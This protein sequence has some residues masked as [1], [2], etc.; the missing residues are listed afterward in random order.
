MGERYELIVLGAGPGGYVAAIKAAQ[1]GHRVAVVESRDVGG[2]C[3][4][5]GCI[6]TKPL[7]HAAE[8]LEEIRSCEKL[9]IHVGQVSY[10]FAGMHERKAEVVEQLRGGIEGLFK[11]YKIDLIR[12]CGI[13]L[14]SN[15]IQV[16]DQAYETD[17]ILIATGS[18]PA[19]P[20]IPGLT[21]PGVVTSDEMLEGKGVYCK[22][23]VIIG[24]GVI[25][26]EFAT[27]YHALGCEVTIIEALD[28]I[29]PTLDREVSQNLT[30]ILK[31]RGI[32]VYTGA[33]VDRVE[34][35][36]QSVQTAQEKGLAVYFMSKEKEQCVETERVLVSIGRRANTEGICPPSLNLQMQRGMIPV[37]DSFETCIKGIYAIGDIVLGGIQ[38]AHVASAQAVN[39]VCSMFGERAPMNLS[40]IPSCIYTNPEIAAVG[41]TA[42]EAKMR[43]IRTITGK[44]IMSSNG[45]TVI[46]MADR[47]FVKLVFEEESKVLLGA[48]LMCSRATDMITGL[49]DGVAGKLTMS[50]LAATVR[51]HPTFSE[52]I[53]EAIE[54][55]DGGAIHAAPRRK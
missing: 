4:N 39:A 2:T 17:R 9:G 36:D 54:D 37:D 7:V 16:G 6:P 52:A 48:V 22:K 45:K 51:P 33:R 15:R 30:M 47:G 34:H 24:G 41:M 3:L 8:V 19:M 42:D 13:I 21:L 46:E 10:N 50:Q 14:D 1:M 31:K 38:L 18:K 26:V 44:A 43:G 20:P 28:R 11:A 49:S 40:C 25:G 12:G 55:A 23:L 29:L 32:K 27:I 35:T 53:G 5:R